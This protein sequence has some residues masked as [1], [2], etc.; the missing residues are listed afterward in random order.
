MAIHCFKKDAVGLG[1]LLIVYMMMIIGNLLFLY[2]AMWPIFFGG[3][4][5][6]AGPITEITVFELLWTFMFWSHTY[7]MCTDPGFIPVNYRYDVQKLPTNFKQV[8]S[9]DS[10][11]NLNANV[12]NSTKSQG[13]IM[14]TDLE[15]QSSKPVVENQSQPI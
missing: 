9:P 10:C 13:P 1:T 5:W 14:S 7:C 12:S 6:S 2:S 11:R 3:V 4:E 15:N 8:I